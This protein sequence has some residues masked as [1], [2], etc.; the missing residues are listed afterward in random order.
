[1]ECPKCGFEQ[2]PSDECVKCGIIISKY[3]RR[4]KEERDPPVDMG[5]KAKRFGFLSSKNKEL[6]QFYIT[7][8]QLLDAGFAPL[9]AFR[10]FI[11][12]GPSVIDVRPYRR[13]DEVLRAGRPASTAML[14]YPSFFPVYHSRLIETGE[15]V[16][17]PEIFYRQLADI[18]D[19]KIQ[20]NREM[21]RSALYPLCL[22]ACAFIIPTL[23]IL[24]TDGLRAYLL[25][26]FVPLAVVATVVVVLAKL[27]RRKDAF[28]GARRI[29]GRVSIR[30]PMVRSFYLIQFTRAFHAL[31]KAGVPA[32]EAIT[33]SNTTVDNQ[34][35]QSKVGQIH[36]SIRNGSSMHEAFSDHDLFPEDFIQFL[37]SGEISGKLDFS[38]QKYLDA[39]EE[40]FKARLRACA[41]VLS[42]IL[43]FGIM[44]FVALRIITQYVG[45]FA[46]RFP[47]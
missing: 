12:K 20:M 41:K 26:S 43:E 6:R 22:L 9:K 39:L 30:I 31:N 16:G 18:L 44:G 47:A 24:F 33:I 1:M 36:E 28:E 35:F 15:R 3:L 11:D 17:T 21:I 34:L 27:Y 10:H 14:E 23:P 32:L 29:V 13:I 8:Y 46:L 38:L 2:S 19:D 7:L 45:V 37:S 40:Q 25:N 4:R 5:R 42:R